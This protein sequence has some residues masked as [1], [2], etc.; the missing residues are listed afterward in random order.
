MPK[1]SSRTPAKGSKA[2]SKKGS[3]SKYI[4]KQEKKDKGK[5]LKLL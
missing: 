2:A 3:V 4:N 5:S 1:E